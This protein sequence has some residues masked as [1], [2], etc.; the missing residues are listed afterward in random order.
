MQTAPF[1]LSSLAWTDYRLAILFTVAVPLVLLIWA[2]TQRSEA[3][4]RLLIIYWRVSSLLAIAV[5]LLIGAFPIGF[6]AGWLARILMPISLWFWADL[7]EE[8]RDQPSSPLRLSLTSW[9]WAVSIYCVLGVLI[10]IPTY[11]RCAL[12]SSQQLVSDASCSVWL[13]PPWLFRE[14]VHAGA[15]PYFLG[16]LGL[17][18]L[19][20]YVL[21]L[22]YFVFFRLGKRKRSAMG[23]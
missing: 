10:Q 18:G 7:N 4:Q 1:W 6:A 21:Y 8:I 16:F 9:R 19:G 20:I 5:Y 2:F 11:L 3:I 22:G 12:L 23:N 17:I 14:Y 15:R 13:A